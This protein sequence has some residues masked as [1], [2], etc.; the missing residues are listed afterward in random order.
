MD[1][2]LGRGVDLV[3]GLGNLTF[4]LSQLLNLQQN[5]NKDFKLRKRYIGL[6]GREG[7]L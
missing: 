6:F 4:T 3:L 7:K 5:K 1:I 2:T